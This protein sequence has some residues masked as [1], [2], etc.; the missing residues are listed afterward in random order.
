M[1]SGHFPCGSAGKEPACLLQRQEAR[2]QSLVG[3]I[4]WRRKQQPTPVFMPEK[5]LMDKGAW[6]LK[7]LV[8]TERGRHTMPCGTDW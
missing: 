5:N 1:V 7:E 4:P 8:M 2:V 6:G 3:K